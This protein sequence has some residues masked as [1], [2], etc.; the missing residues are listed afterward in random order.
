MK[1]SIKLISENGSGCYLSVK[2]RTEW[3][4]KRCALKHAGDVMGCK[5]VLFGAIV[6]HIETE[7]G[8]IVAVVE[9]G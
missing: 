8:E 2:G 5:V 6:A 4:T 9:K 1:Y 3:K 7:H